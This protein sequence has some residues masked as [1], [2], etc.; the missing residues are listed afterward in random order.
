[1]EKFQKL[2]LNYTNVFAK[3]TLNY[4]NANRS[5]CVYLW[6]VFWYNHYVIL[7]GDGRT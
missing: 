5:I 1:M 3:L 6:R 4:T 7:R 2:T